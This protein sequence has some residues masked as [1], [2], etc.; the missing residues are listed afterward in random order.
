MTRPSYKKGRDRAFII[1]S[2]PWITM[3]NSFGELFRLTTF[4]ESHGAAVGAVVDGCPAGLLLA[5][6]D[7]QRELDRR[8][9]GQSGVSTKRSEADRVEILSGTFEGKTLGTPIA[10]LVENRDADSRPYR[11]L[12]DA[13]RPGH[14]DFAWR[15][16]FGHVDWRGGGRASARETVGRVAGGAVARKLL[17]EH[18]IEVV[19]FSREIG[20]VSLV[21]DP[22]VSSFEKLR[23]QVERNAV[24]CPVPS[25]ACEMQAAVEEAKAGK[26]SVGGIVEVIA[27]GVPPGLG[28]PVFDKLDAELAKAVMSVPAVKAVEIGEGFMASCLSGS[29]ANDPFTWKARKVATKTNIAGGINGGLSNGMPVVV[30]AFVK[31]TASIGLPQ[32]TV[33]LSSKKKASIEITGRHD[34]CIVPRA[35]P[36]VEAMVCLVLADH[37][38]RSGV[39][40]RRL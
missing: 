13:P 8:R 40:A 23:K 33:D 19:G 26:D 17:V 10:M 21:E 39:I 15:A 2:S 38:L 29:Q 30:R 1:A 20:G 32:E 4:G 34:P 18:S 16:K 9:P 3:N 36:V 6:K 37:G 27:T 25:V 35:V 22:D 7:V 14:A 12:K 24:R 28:E 5:E 11:K 31:P